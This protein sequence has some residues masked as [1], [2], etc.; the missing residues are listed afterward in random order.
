MPNLPLSALSTASPIVTTP[1][2]T[3]FIY[4][5]GSNMDKIYRASINTATGALAEH[6]ATDTS[7]GDQ[8]VA[9]A[10]STNK[11]YL[12][13]GK[14]AAN[15][16]DTYSLNQT[17]GE[18][19]LIYSSAT[20]T[21]P[22]KIVVEPLGRFLYVVEESLIETYMIANNGSLTWRQSMNIGSGGSDVAIDAAG[23]FLYLATL[24]TGTWSYEIDQAGGTL[25]NPSTVISL[26][27]KAI[28]INSASGHIFGTSY[29]DGRITNFNYDSGTGAYSFNTY[30]D[31]GVTFPFYDL[32]LNVAGTVAYALGNYLGIVK[33]FTINASTGAF[34]SLNT[35]TLPAECSPVQLTRLAIADFLYTGCTDGSGITQVLKIEADGSLSMPSRSVRPEMKVHSIVSV[36]F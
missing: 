17:T 2:S 1:V 7:F 16:I 19:T 21:E 30:M 33:S 31:T 24:D 12:F 14:K 6:P 3:S 23:T 28:K 5:V 25:S 20:S 29:S 26:G 18:P 27:M 15:K 9:L 32:Q 8:P 35:A 11:Q 34:T 13:V 4:R 10:V 22:V 36:N